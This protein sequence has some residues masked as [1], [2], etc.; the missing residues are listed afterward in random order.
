MLRK[1]D[2]SEEGNQFSLEGEIMMSLFAIIL[3]ALPLAFAWEGCSGNRITNV[4]NVH[5]YMIER[6]GD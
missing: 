6:T 3:I 4:E 2:T 1:N 5:Q